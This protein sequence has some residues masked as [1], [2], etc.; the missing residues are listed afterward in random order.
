M[1]SFLRQHLTLT[2]APGGPI[3]ERHFTVHHEIAPMRT[4]GGESR[5]LLTLPNKGWP[6]F[7]SSFQWPWLTSAMYRCILLEIVHLPLH[8]CSGGEINFRHHLGNC[9]VLDSGKQ[10][11][12]LKTISC[13]RRQFRKLVCITAN[14]QLLGTF[15]RAETFSRYLQVTSETSTGLSDHTTSIVSPK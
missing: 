4:R 14:L 8:G 11:E 2:P 15:P 6:F 5:S 9:R 12:S 10:P 3:G 13:M 1:L 7:S